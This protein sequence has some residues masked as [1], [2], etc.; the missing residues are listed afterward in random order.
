MPSSEHDII[1]ILIRA[2]G[3]L[4]EPLNKAGPVGAPLLKVNVTDPHL[5]FWLLP[6]PVLYE[7]CATLPWLDMVSGDRQ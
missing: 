6:P 4:H 1:I 2:A 7:L 5:R 3:H